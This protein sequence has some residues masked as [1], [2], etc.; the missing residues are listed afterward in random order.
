MPPPVRPGGKLT[1]QAALCML[2]RGCEKFEIHDNR[3]VFTVRQNAVIRHQ[4]I[5]HDATPET[6]RHWSYE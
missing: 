4:L 1:E 2:R 3:L 5:M 6:P